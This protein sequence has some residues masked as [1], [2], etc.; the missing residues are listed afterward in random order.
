MT[1]ATPQD[2]YRAG[3]LQEAI[4]S[5]LEAVKQ[6]PTNQSSRGLL[7]ELLCFAGDYERADRHLEAL[8]HQDEALTVGIA[9]F[10]QLVRAEQARQQ[11]Y[12]EG[13]LPE[14]LT[15]PSPCLKLHLEASL[16]ARSGE[17][18]EAAKLL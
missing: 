5:A 2:H 8:V 11:F 3:R 4:T 15:P 18:A 7:A 17:L 6:A 10:R 16:R 9:V 1:T 12:S 14:F 13:R